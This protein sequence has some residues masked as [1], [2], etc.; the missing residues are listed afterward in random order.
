MSHSP[1]TCVS[2][3]ARPSLAIRLLS[4]ARS[5]QCA[6]VKWYERRAARHHLGSLD[7]RLLKDI[8]ISR[9]EIEPAVRGDRF[10]RNGRHAG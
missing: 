3:V 4:A 7:D 1:S 8:G 5:A 2:P 6:Y 10:R 9:S